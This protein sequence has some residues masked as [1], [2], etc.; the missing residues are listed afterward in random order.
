[1]SMQGFIQS[2]ERQSTVKLLSGSREYRRVFSVAICIYG[3]GIDNLL[4]APTAV[5]EGPLLG[6]IF[7][8]TFSR[9]PF[10]LILYQHTIQV[11][12]Y[13]I[14]SSQVIA[15]KTC[16]SCN[17]D[18]ISKYIPSLEMLIDIWNA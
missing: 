1:M 3:S 6:S 5:E 2:L 9:L 10:S 8:R 7:Q 16:L 18:Q 11:L 13:M 14:N 15:N 12:R 4:F 17:I